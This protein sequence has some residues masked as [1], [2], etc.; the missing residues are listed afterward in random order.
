MPIQRPNT[1][2]RTLSGRRREKSVATPC[3]ASVGGGCSRDRALL[4]A[5]V[6]AVALLMMTPSVHARPLGGQITAPS[7]AAAAAAQSNAQ[8]A[9][10]AARQAQNALKRATQAI[11]AMQAAQSAARNAAQAAQSSIPNGLRPGGLRVAPGAVPGSDL[12]QGAGLP[13]E[14][15]TG[16]Q[17]EVTVKQNQQKAILTWETFNVGKQTA[18]YFNQSAGTGADG[19]NAWMVL[20]RVLDPAAAPSRILG[21]IKAEGQVYIV[22]QNGIIF[23]GASQINVGTLVASTPNILDATFKGTL[24]DTRWDQFEAPV[25]FTNGPVGDVKV[26]RGAKIIAEHGGRVVLLGQNVSNSGELQ[27]DD[28]QVGCRQA[29]PLAR[30][31]H[32]QS[33]RL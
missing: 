16:A 2:S 24:A 32:K 1:G 11:Q 33:A 13:T 21:S 27:A 6:S 5:G 10:Q 23:G 29:Y 22:N 20:N 8:G 26:E 25:F 28:G 15:V 14:T 7:A 3:A 18:L 4:L 19:S 9:A 31:R 30:E 17:T 12:W